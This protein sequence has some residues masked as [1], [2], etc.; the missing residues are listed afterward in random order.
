MQERLLPYDG[1]GYMW[2]GVSASPALIYS[3]EGDDCM[4]LRGKK[5]EEPHLCKI[6]SSSPTSASSLAQ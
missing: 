6:G 4:W 3:S 2:P 1:W 5:C